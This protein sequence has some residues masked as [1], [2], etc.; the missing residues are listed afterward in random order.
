VSWLQTKQ[1][2][3]LIESYSVAA[4]ELAAIKAQ[5]S[6]QDTEE[7]W[8]RFVKEAEEAISREHILWKA[9]RTR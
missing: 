1:H 5:I 6:P 8:A 7:A 4:Q 9:S 2:S 3:N